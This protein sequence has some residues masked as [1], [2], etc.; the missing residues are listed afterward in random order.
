MGQIGHGSNAERM[1]VFRM[2][3]LIRRSHTFC[4]CVLFCQS[5]PSPWAGGMLATQP[6]RSGRMIFAT[7]FYFPGQTCRYL[8][9]PNM[10]DLLPAARSST[11]TA[12]IS[13]RAQRPRASKATDKLQ[14]SWM[15]TEAFAAHLTSPLGG[16]SVHWGT[17][18]RITE[19][20]I[21]RE[22][23]L[24]VI[25]SVSHFRKENWIQFLWPSCLSLTMSV[26]KVLLIVNFKV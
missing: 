2:S 5:L 1:R 4:Q 7:N 17:F 15:V 14:S 19:P 11:W 8:N 10:M 13:S 12:N 25:S 18:S 26:L 21:A 6:A 24:C 20:V 3:W 22:M 16:W 9:T 23:F